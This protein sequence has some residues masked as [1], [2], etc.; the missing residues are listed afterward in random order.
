MDRAAAALLT[1]VALFKVGEIV[2]DRDH[3]HFG[4]D[5][6]LKSEEFEEK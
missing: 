5:H 2:L 3:L 4:L 6:W 1:H